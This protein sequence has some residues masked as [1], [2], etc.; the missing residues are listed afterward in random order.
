MVDFAYLKMT[1]Y[2]R[3]NNLA[4]SNSMRSGNRPNSSIKYNNNN[5]SSNR[6]YQMNFIGSKWPSRLHNCCNS[7]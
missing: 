4:C 2:V 1:K 6:N 7:I 3:S 5:N